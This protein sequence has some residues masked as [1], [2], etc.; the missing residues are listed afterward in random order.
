M[1]VAKKAL[2]PYELTSLVISFLGLISLIII[3]TQTRA[4]TTQ[5]KNS[6]ASLHSSAYQAITTQEME[7]DKLFVENPTL[8]PYFFSGKEIREDNLDYALAESIADYE[9]DFFDSAQ[10]QLRLLQEL[11]PTSIDKEAWDAYFDDSFAHSPILCR[12]LNELATW[13]GHALVDR[14]RDVCSK[15]S[16]NRS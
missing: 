15:A 14:E 16:K 1:I 3:Y 13:Y 2:T 10:S 11:E 12:R 4:I 5:T 8:R 9:L 7:V 6:A